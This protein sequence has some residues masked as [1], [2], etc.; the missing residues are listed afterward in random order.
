MASSE[1][2][3]KYWPPHRPRDI[4]LPDT[5]IW[6]NLEVSARRFGKKTATIFYDS[7]LTYDEMKAD[8]ESLAGFLQRECGVRRGD[9]VALYMQNSPQFIVAYYAILRA[10]AMVV[11]INTMNRGMELAA[12]IYDCGANVLIAPQDLLASAEPLVGRSVKHLIVACYA[13]SLT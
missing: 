6:V 3:R 1:P 7:P 5:S 13:D 9:R 10:D 4:S 8:A 11:P 12:I 2:Y